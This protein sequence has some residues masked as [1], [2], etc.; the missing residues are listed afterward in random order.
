MNAGSVTV[1]IT[2]LCT[3]VFGHLT[4]NPFKKTQV[5]IQILP[6]LHLNTS[7]VVKR[8]IVVNQ[9]QNGKQCRSR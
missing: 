9:K 4:F 1:E 8:V 7:I 3:T 5:S 2:M 6:S